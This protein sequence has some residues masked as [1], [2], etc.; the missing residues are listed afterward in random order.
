MTLEQQESLARELDGAME[1]GDPKRITCAQSNILLSLM[2]CQRKTS[3]RVK[4]LSWKFMVAMVAL[5][6]SLGF[7]VGKC[8]LA[9]VIKSILGIG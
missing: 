2:D 8:E 3:E 5:G 1:S 7:G 9:S 6:S 4:R